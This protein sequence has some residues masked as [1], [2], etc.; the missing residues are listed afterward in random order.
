MREGSRWSKRTISNRFLDARAGKSQPELRATAITNLTPLN[1]RKKLQPEL[2][3]YISCEDTRRRGQVGGS[4]K[5][6]QKAKIIGNG[7]KIIA[8]LDTIPDLWVNI[9]T[10]TILG[11]LKPQKYSILKIHT[12]N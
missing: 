9:K 11:A 7:T 6:S 5:G 8:C 1:Y 12:T 3:S 2:L 10:I 4:A